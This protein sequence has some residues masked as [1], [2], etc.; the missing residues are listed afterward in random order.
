M[1]L[2]SGTRLSPSAAGFPLC[3]RY[4]PW[5]PGVRDRL[6]V[7]VSSTMGLASLE[8]VPLV[9]WVW[10]L[11]SWCLFYNGISFTGVGV[12]ATMGSASLELVSLLQWVWLLY[13]WCLF[14]NGISFAGVGVSGRMELA[15]R[16]WCIGIDLALM[17]L[18]RRDWLGFGVSATMGSAWRLWYNGISL[19]LVAPVQRDRLG[20]GVSDTEISLDLVSLL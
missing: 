14:Y 16:L 19:A 13:S 2:L 15:W 18:V 6:K 9:Q 20:F 17:A 1:E 11:C 8:L 5:C 12:S 3:C 4:V 7:G 10:L